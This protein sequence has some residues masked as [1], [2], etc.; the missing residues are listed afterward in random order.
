MILFCWRYFSQSAGDRVRDCT[1]WSTYS[2]AL[3][4]SRAAPRAGCAPWTR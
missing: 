2:K 1:M 4:E 3:A